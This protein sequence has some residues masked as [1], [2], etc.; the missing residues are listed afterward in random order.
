MGKQANKR[1]AVKRQADKLRT[2]YEAR[3]N[4]KALKQQFDNYGNEI[5]F[6][7]YGNE[8]TNESA[9][10]DGADQARD[11]AAQDGV[12]VPENLEKPLDYY[13]NMLYGIIDGFTG[14]FD[15]NCSSALYG[16]VNGGFRA[17]EY[18]SVY[19]PTST[20]KFQL[21]VT[22]FIDSTNS[23]YTFCDFTHLYAQFAMLTDTEDWEQYIQISSRVTG[24]FVQ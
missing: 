8:I 21:A 19:K 3:Q 13:E 1:L 11:Q 14:P 6:D 20:I 18:K 9:F 4:N 2:A 17:N 23:M 5:F 15:A 12:Y 7:D 24:S 10:D 16:V 22:N